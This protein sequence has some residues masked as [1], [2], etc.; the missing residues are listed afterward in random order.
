MAEITFR[1]D[2]SREIGTGHVMRC[3]TLGRVLR[4]AGHGVRFVTRDLPGHMGARLSSLGLPVD[5]LPA[6]ERDLAPA[7]GDTAHAAWASVS[8]QQDAVETAAVLKTARP[9]WL[10][11]DHYAFDS[12]WQ[13]AV[14]AQTGRI[15]V[16]DDLAD[17]PHVCDLLLDQNLGRS[18]DSYLGLVPE[19]A[20]I[21]AGPAYA[22]LRPDF[23]S[24]RKAA[25]AARQG[26]G[27]GLARILVSMGGVDLPN[28][29]GEVL[30]VLAR[31][32]GLGGV[33]V[34]VILGSRAPAIAAIRRRAAALPMPV[35]L[36]VDVDDMAAR[37]ARA[38]L[39]IG[40]V[41][42]TTWE[43]CALG[44]PGLMLTIAANQRPAAQALHNAGAGILLGD[45]SDNHWR[46]NLSRLLSSGDLQRRLEATSHVASA[47]CD[48]AG[49]DRVLAEMIAGS[50]LV[51]DPEP[52]GATG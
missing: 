4:D 18:P 39:A 2:A 52:G 41:G 51:A 8:W 50:A 34:E 20:R 16:W 30:D 3:L 27:R 35:E 17:R 26:R 40:A 21:L 6:P 45:L 47:L 48:G 13:S 22:V 5:L 24:L 33:R 12:R 10:V 32:P 36:A 44:L 31:T 7:E 11:V 9:D 29:T 38:D 49:A 42:G 23:A 1:A 46:D 28:A 37:M 19:G 25:L 14:A 43:R 15:M